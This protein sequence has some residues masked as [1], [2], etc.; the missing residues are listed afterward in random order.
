MA[1]DFTTTSLEGE[2]LLKLWGEIIYSTELDNQPNL[3]II[4]WKIK[5]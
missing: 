2:M 4:Q 1:I 5:P 3:Q